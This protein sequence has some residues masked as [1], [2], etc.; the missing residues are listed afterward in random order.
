MNPTIEKKEL[1]LAVLM[2]VIREQLAAGR[3]VRFGPKGTSMRPMLR[4]GIDDVELSALPESLKKYDLPLYQRDNGQYVLH[5]IVKAGDTFTCIGDNQYLR[6][7]GV[8][9]DQ[10]IGLV[11]A[12]YR[13]D[14]R[15]PVTAWHYR[16]YCRLWHHSRWARHILWH[17]RYG[18]AQH[19]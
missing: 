11:T 16:L 14:K 18:N 6:E 3:S 17:C 15:Y 2:P 12:F 19:T 10:M 8:R 9:P 4:Q 1:R 5:R 13:G 7:T